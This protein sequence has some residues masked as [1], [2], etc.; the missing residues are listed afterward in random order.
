MGDGCC[1]KLFLTNL[2]ENTSRLFDLPACNPQMTNTGMK[3]KTDE[4]LGK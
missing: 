3:Y 1:N 4:S 2:Q